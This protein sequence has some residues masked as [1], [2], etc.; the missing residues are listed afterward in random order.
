[1]ILDWLKGEAIDIIIDET[2]DPKKADANRAEVS[3]WR[4]ASLRISYGEASPTSTACVRT[5]QSDRINGASLS[6]FLVMGIPK[7]VM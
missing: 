1:L 2:G 6:E 3:V 7:L 4:H 5:K